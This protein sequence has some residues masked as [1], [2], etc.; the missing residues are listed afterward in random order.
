MPID[1]RSSR[2][3]G[4]PEWLERAAL[5]FQPF[6]PAI[7]FGAP[8][9]LIPTFFVPIALVLHALS[10]RKL[11]L[12]RSRRAEPEAAGLASLPRPVAP[13]A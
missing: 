6:V 10:L 5:G 11:V 2:S 9:T 7:F 13:A 1:Y 4:S 3:G 12:E 8:L